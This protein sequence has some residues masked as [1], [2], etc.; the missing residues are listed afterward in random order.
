[1]YV[2]HYPECCHADTVLNSW[3]GV[4]FVSKLLSDLVCT[5]ADQTAAKGTVPNDRFP[6]GL[7]DTRPISLSP[8]VPLRG[9]SGCW[10]GHAVLHVPFCVS[11]CFHEHWP[12]LR[13][14]RYTKTACSPRQIIEA[15][16]LGHDLGCRD[17][18]EQV[19]CVF[20]S[21]TTQV[22]NSSEGL[23]RKWLVK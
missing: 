9:V 12:T 21:A 5:G 13:L 3:L 19:P 8:S 15:A 1:M 16:C 7:W 6:P 18:S 2:P 11:S 10:A 20:F 14:S 23:V 17:R 22:S 4:S